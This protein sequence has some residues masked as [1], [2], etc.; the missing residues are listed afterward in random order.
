M[1]HAKEGIFLSEW[2]F[3]DIA[4]EFYG[5]VGQR[6]LVYLTDPHEAIEKSVWCYDRNVVPLIGEK[7]SDIAMFAAEK[8]QIDSLIT[9]PA[10]I[11]RIR[12]YLEKRDTKLRYISIIAPSFAISDL[13]PYRAFARAVTLVRALPETGAIESANLEKRP[14]FAPCGG[15]LIERDGM[16]IVTKTRM[17]VTPVIRYRTGIAGDSV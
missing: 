1:V 4:A 17:L 7:D 11:A 3:S 10:A 6:P 12:P 9:D 8:Y 5:D 16:L 14:R 2:R 13:M 15:C